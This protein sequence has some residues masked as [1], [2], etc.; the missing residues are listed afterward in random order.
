MDGRQ[1]SEKGEKQMKKDEGR[2][3]NPQANRV[4]RGPLGGPEAVPIG[5]SYGKSQSQLDQGFSSEG[6]A[7]AKFPTQPPQIDNP[8][9]HKK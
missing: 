7:A 9:G 1:H 4:K 8:C 2:N 6:K 5:K 3:I